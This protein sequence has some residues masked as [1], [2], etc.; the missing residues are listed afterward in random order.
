MARILI[1]GKYYFPFQ[2]GIEA[3]TQTLAEHLAERHEVTVLV[4]NHERGDEVTVINGV[5]VIRCATYLKIKNQPLSPAMLWRIF[6]LRPDIIDFQAPN[7]VGNAA[8]LLREAFDTR[9]I[10]VIVTHHMDVHGRAVLRAMCIPLYRA[11]TRRAAA[12]I[13]TSAKNAAISRDLNKE[14][15]THA[16]PLGIDLEKYA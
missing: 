14:V 8:V 3:Y 10:Q 16:I 11:L 2:G 15:P 1:V 12:V 7:F 5:R 6:A 4:H 9:G 13:V